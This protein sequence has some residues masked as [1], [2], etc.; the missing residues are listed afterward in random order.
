[1][2]TA[3][4]Y[5]Q[6][7]G[8]PYASAGCSYR[9]EHPRY[10]LKEETDDQRSLVSAGVFDV[11]IDQLRVCINYRE[12]LGLVGKANGYGSNVALRE[13]TANQRTLMS[14]PN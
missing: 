9:G 8:I 3:R 13:E 2:E 7:Y 14:G 1:M 6:T 11:C 10:T 4:I 12:Y 5:Q